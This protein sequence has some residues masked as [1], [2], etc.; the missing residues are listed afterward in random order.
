MSSMDRNLQLNTDTI[1]LKCT[2]RPTNYFPIQLIFFL[3]SAWC[4][5]PSASCTFDKF[6]IQSYII[7]GLSNWNYNQIW[8][9]TA[10]PAISIQFEVAQSCHH[11]YLLRFCGCENNDEDKL[12]RFDV[13]LWYSVL[14][15]IADMRQSWPVFGLESDDIFLSDRCL[16][17]NPKTS[18]S[19]AVPRISHQCELMCKIEWVRHQLFADRRFKIN[20]FC[21]WKFPNQTFHA[22]VN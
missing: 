13:L 17:I 14:L 21:C 8:L 19:A 3:V 7:C 20:T 11:E 6:K 16:V 2:R 15:V 4:P 1:T 18:F 10:M 12:L 9:S 22:F 5:M